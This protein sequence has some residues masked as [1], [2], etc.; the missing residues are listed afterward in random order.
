MI[1]IR[2]PEAGSTVVLWGTTDFPN[3]STKRGFSMVPLVVDANAIGYHVFS[4]CCFIIAPRPYED[5]SVHSHRG[6]FES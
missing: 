5:T 1:V 2:N 6:R 3:H 4:H